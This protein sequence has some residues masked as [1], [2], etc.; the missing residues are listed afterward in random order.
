VIADVAMSPTAAAIYQ[1]RFEQD[2]LAT[3]LVETVELM[4]GTWPQLEVWPHEK[5][6]WALAAA[7][8]MLDGMP[9]PERRTLGDLLGDAEVN[10]RTHLVDAVQDTPETAELGEH[11]RLRNVL[12][13]MR[14]TVALTMQE[15][16]LQQLPAASYTFGLRPLAPLPRSSRRPLTDDEAALLRLVAEL[17]SMHGVEPGPALVALGLAGLT[18]AEAT[19][20][21]SDAIE[22]DTMEAPGCWGVAKRIVPLPPW[23]ARILQEAVGRRHH[24]L[25]APSVPLAYRS[26]DPHHPHNASASADGVYKRMMQRVGITASDVKASSVPLWRPDHLIRAHGDL[27][28]ALLVSGRHLENLLARLHLSL[29]QVATF[30]GRTELTDPR[31]NVVNSVPN[32]EIHPTPRKSR[33]RPRGETEG[34]PRVRV[35]TTGEN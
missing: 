19:T 2:L 6:P 24:G 34:W 13:A 18:A 31:G 14:V 21:A 17:D 32:C 1:R 28:A 27:S 11:H 3:R 4:E 33:K 8:A 5:L 15:A 7:Q 12:V 9:S 35:S 22:T 16:G 25:Y 23:S 29:K 20:V 30:T 10:L 26:A